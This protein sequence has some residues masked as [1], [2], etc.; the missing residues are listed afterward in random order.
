MGIGTFLVFFFLVAAVVIWFLSASCTPLE[1]LLA[2]GIFTFVF[3]V[4]SLVLVYAP[5]T[6]Q[7]YTNGYETIVSIRCSIHSNVSVSSIIVYFLY[8]Y[9]NHIYV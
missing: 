9:T 4:T 6:Q 3:M 5:R 7:T 2:R 1:K 8:I